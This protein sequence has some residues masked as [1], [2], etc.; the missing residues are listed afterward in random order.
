MRLMLQLDTPEDFVIASGQPHSVMEL[1]KLAF[2]ELGMDYAKHVRVRPELMRRTPRQVPL[3][4]D[5]AKL[6][7]ATGWAPSVSFGDMIKRMVRAELASRS[8]A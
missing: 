8:A 3:V 1:A 7:G 2:G 5:A 6:R 4:G